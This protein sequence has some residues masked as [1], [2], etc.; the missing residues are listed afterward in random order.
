M[1]TIVNERTPMHAM[2]KTAAVLWC[3]IVQ[4]V[5]PKYEALMASEAGRHMHVM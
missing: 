2:L 1:D 3:C 4:H 5:V